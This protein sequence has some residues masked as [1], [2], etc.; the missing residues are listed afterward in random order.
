MA[1]FGIEFLAVTLL[2]AS[3]AAAIPAFARRENQGC[4]FCHSNFPKLNSTGQLYRANGFRFPGAEVK[5]LWDMRGG[6]PLALIAEIEGFIDHENRKNENNITDGPDLK[7]D[8]VEILAAGNMSSRVSGFVEVAFA[9][10]GSPELG[11]G[12]MQVNDL[13]GDEGQL[14]FRVGKMDVDLPFL[15]QARRVVRNK[16]LAFDKLGL[17]DA[18]T[19]AEFVGQTIGEGDDGLIQRY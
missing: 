17:L 16:F 15:S 6:P 5:N 8:E 3:P 2:A 1:L 7:I 11:V 14:N 18:E 4:E 13:V 19:G 10:D 12:W 9:S